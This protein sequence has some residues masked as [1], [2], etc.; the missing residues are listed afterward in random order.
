MMNFLMTKR[1]TTLPFALFAT[2][3]LLIAASA[4]QAN[5]NPS[6]SDSKCI[7]C[8]SRAL[9]KSLEDGGQLSLQVT[10]AHFEQSVHANIGCT[11]CHRDIAKV[12]HP[13]QKKV[14]ASARD[15]SAAQ[16]ENCRRCHAGKFKAYEGSIHS[17]LAAAGNADAP[18]CSDCHSA[19]AIQT[20]TVYEPVT[21]EP[22][23]GCHENIY[24]AYAG[25][26]HGVARSNGNVIRASH[27]QAPI[28][29]DC[30]SAHE[31]NAV[32]AT[33][34]L[35]TACLD[36]HEGAKLAHEQWL[37]NAGMHLDSVSCA[38]CHAPMAERRIDLQLYDELAG[39][40]VGGNGDHAEVANRLAEIDA[41]GDALDPLE[42]WKL[43]R[44]G[45]REG[46]ATNVTLR[47]RME[48]TTGVDAHRI[49]PRL[50][51]VRS[52]ESCHQSGSEAFQQVTVSISGPDGRKQRVEADS[53]VLSSA[54]SVDSIRGFYAPGG[55]RIRLLDGLLVLAIV[56]GLA[57]P[58]GH[59][60]LGKFLRSRREKEK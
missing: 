47:G 31:V 20:M 50:D 56:G 4:A 32:A 14:I 59:I 39:M 22:C 23:K 30:H 57:V 21:G 9:N 13:K 19:H 53:D 6:V 25:S 34:H 52:C 37:P 51:A 38:A 11:G 46:H 35:K 36:C 27:I 28:C 54:I 60:A 17:S 7:K 45:S 43:V 26:V 10:A 24:Q 44:L 41:G 40:P 3:L 5:E 58:A 33:G 1:S 8:H 12:K 18:L 42:L 55:T 16:N 2:V 48:V 29:A 49:A 15:Y